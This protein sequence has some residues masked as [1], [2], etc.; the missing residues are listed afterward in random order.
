MWVSRGPQACGAPTTAKGAPR[1]PSPLGTSLT[2]L[3]IS[4]ARLYFH[5]ST[6]YTFTGHLQEVTRIPPS[7]TVPRPH[8]ARH[9]A[10]MP[11]EC[12]CYSHCRS[13]IYAWSARALHT[14]MFSTR[15]NWY[16]VLG[17]DGC[18]TKQYSDTFLHLQLIFVFA[19]FPTLKNT[20]STHRA[21]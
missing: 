10:R 16:I 1:P 2:V 4:C 3:R 8:P 7:P 11:L 17:H 14:P 5:H 9:T 21:K 12:V 13:L 18:S 6:V 15:N 20:R 19:F